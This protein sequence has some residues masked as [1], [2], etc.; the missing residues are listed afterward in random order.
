MLSD[1]LTAADIIVFDSAA[2]IIVFGSA[3]D[4][5]I[6]DSAA[7]NVIFDSAADNVIYDSAADNI[8]FGSAADILYLVFHNP[9]R[10]LLCM[11]SW[12][13]EHIDSIM[14]VQQRRVSCI[15]AD[16]LSHGFH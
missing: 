7:D 3:A 1:C 13:V 9:T 10:L 8:I 15:T 12:N 4:N 5:V 6:F 2:D 11:R 14:Y 16:Q